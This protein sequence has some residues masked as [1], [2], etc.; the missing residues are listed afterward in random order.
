VRGLWDTWEDGAIVADNRTGKFLD[1]SKGRRL[2]HKGRFYSV[3]GPLNIERCPQGHP[4]II[5][6]GGSPPGQEVSARVADVVFSVVNG[7]TE[8]A[9]TNYNS[10]KGRM[11]KYGR[12]PNDIAILPGVMPIVGESES[13]PRNQRPHRSGEI[14]QLV[15]AQ[16]R[17]EPAVDLNV[18]RGARPIRH[19]P[20]MASR[21]DPG[22][23]AT[24]AA[25]AHLNFN[26]SAV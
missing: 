10:L 12:E 25:D 7:D 5:Q 14:G 6:A 26:P 4:I 21:V 9:K 17:G 16:E 22:R 2:N 3:Q 11:A 13:V 15:D 1:E 24:P 23:P 18:H 8:L 20:M 19:D